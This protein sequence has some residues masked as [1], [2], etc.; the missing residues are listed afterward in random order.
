VGDGTIQMCLYTNDANNNPDTAIASVN[1]SVTS[2][3]WSQFAL[4]DNGKWLYLVR[5]TK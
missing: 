2:V 1:T 5:C 3:G 4:S